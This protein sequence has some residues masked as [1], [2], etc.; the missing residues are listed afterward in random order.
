MIFR[1]NSAQLGVKMEKALN[2]LLAEMQKTQEEEIEVIADDFPYN[3]IVKAAN[4]KTAKIVWDVDS[5]TYKYVGEPLP[6]TDPNEKVGKIKEFVRPESAQQ[7]P[8]PP[9]QAPAQAPEPAQEFSVTV[10][11]VVS[12][13]MGLAPDQRTKFFCEAWKAIDDEEKSK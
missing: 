3:L 2:T 6:V 12:Q 7:E 8:G 1:F 10:D 9:A 5:Q 11:S 13:F 4:G